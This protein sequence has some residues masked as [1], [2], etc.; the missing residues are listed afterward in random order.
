MDSRTDVEMTVAHLVSAFFQWQEDHPFEAKEVSF[1]FVE[2]T[3]T[4]LDFKAKGMLFQLL[5]PSLLLQKGVQSDEI[6]IAMNPDNSAHSGLMVVVNEKLERVSVGP[7]ALEQGLDVFAKALISYEGKRKRQHESLDHEI[8]STFEGTLANRLGVQGEKLSDSDSDADADLSSDD[9]LEGHFKGFL[10]GI[11]RE[12]SER[13]QAARQRSV[14][15]FRFVSVRPSYSGQSG[16]LYVDDILQFCEVSTASNNC[17]VRI[18]AEV[19]GFVNDMKIAASL[20]LPCSRTIQIFL[21]FDKQFWVER[22]LKQP[23]T[24]NRVAVG[25]QTA[26]SA[27]FLPDVESSWADSMGAGS[28][29][30]FE[31]EC[32]KFHGRQRTVAYGTTVLIPELIKAFFDFRMGK[33]TA[34]ARPRPWENHYMDEALDK[35]TSLENPLIGLIVF[36]G[37]QM[38]ALP[39]WC[40]VCWSL[41]P[42]SVWRLRTCQNDLCLYDFEE[43]GLGATIHHEIQESPEVV[44]LELSL[45]CAAASSERD[46]FEPFPSF[47]LTESVTRGRS[48]WFSEASKQ[49]T[50]KK[51]EAQTSLTNVNM[52]MS[53]YPTAF[54][55]LPTGTT[56][57]M[58][59]TG[60]HPTFSIPGSGTTV[61]VQGSG[62]HGKEREN[63]QLD[64]LLELLQSIPSIAD[65]RE[66]AGDENSLKKKLSKVAFYRW[67]KNPIARAEP[68]QMWLSYELMRFVLSTNRLSL[69]IMREE[70]EFKFGFK[71]KFQFVVI[72][73][74]PEKEA[75]FNERRKM[76]NDS[77]FAFHGSNP[78]NWYSILRNGLRPMSNTK[79][80]STGAAY[81]QGIYLADNLGLSFSYASSAPHAESWKNGSL[82]GGMIVIAICE[83]IKGATT[84]NYGHDHNPNN[85][86]V[87]V[88]PG[89]EDSVSVRYLLVLDPALNNNSSGLSIRG[90]MLHEGFACPQPIDLRKKYERLKQEDQEQQQKILLD[91]RMAAFL[92]LKGESS[93]SQTDTYHVE[94]KLPTFAVTELSCYASPGTEGD[95]PTS[96]DTSPDSKRL[97]E[98]YTRAFTPTALQKSTAKLSVVHNDIGQ[99]KVGTSFSSG[100]R[101]DSASPTQAI[102]G[103]LTIPQNDSNTGNSKPGMHSNGARAETATATQ[104]ITKELKNI[105]REIRK[106]QQ[107]S[108]S[109]GSLG[110]QPFLA[111]ITVEIP[112]EINVYIWHVTLAQDLFSG[113]ANLYKDLQKLA[114][115]KNQLESSVLLEVTF[116]GMYPFEPPFV[117]VVRPKFQ[118]H[119]GHV[120]IGGSICMELLTTTGWL[121]SFSFESVL[122]QIVNAF[123]E[124]EGRID[125]RAVGTEYSKE[126]AQK[127]F[128]R[129]A[130]QHGWTVSKS[131]QQW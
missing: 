96:S 39:S 46:V 59:S 42:T 128:T 92:R 85:H 53:F 13:C 63:K 52:N 18:Q 27:K 87:V 115:L 80:M 15:S 55:N 20:G 32:K 107:G 131:K 101:I 9:H 113:Y 88:P 12:A 22:G 129:V 91:R 106:S 23:L 35:F 69:Q 62:T 11:I 57:M 120:T 103:K 17:R 29:E 47:F 73:D 16:H 28:D 64:V 100:G 37:S 90:A 60:G 108:S 51:T 72:H 50:T 81:G 61:P 102:T 71:P 43:L 86:I 82:K 21:E 49:G 110:S 83:V 40:A 99:V 114:A 105:Q 124:G 48:G 116:P 65:L 97:K 76:M 70:E 33:P 4:T 10:R 6:L 44:D 25:L 36:I 112:D 98:N 14:K 104:A 34:N 2:A 122:V 24:L 56:T 58:S 123:I 125:M 7:R 3:E 84:E 30:E 111:N 5:L 126:E 75:I 95:S 41:L 45:A 79:Y 109:S 31:A 26:R 119:T 117:R 68:C 54:H 78:G 77:F 130:D 19:A 93:C 127:A 1:E 8:T 66:S 94:R 118:F 74:S 89:M 67:R 121:P 38:R